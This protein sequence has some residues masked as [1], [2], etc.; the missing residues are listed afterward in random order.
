VR[1][2]KSRAALD[3]EEAVWLVA[4]ERLGAHKRLGYGSF[5][6]YVSAAVGWD[7]HSAYE[8]IRV[9]HALVTLPRVYEAL[10]EARLSW[11]AV[12]ELTR[13]ATV[14]TEKTWVDACAPLSVRDVQRLVSGRRPGDLPSTPAD[15]SARMHGLC[16]E[17]SGST[18]AL[19]KQAEDEL[20]RR[21]GTSLDH[22]AFMVALAKA[23]L[24]GE[25]ATVGAAAQVSVELCPSCRRG[26][27][28]AGGERVALRASEVERLA[29]DAR[30][31][32]AARERAVRGES[33]PSTKA[34]ADS[35]QEQVAAPSH[36]GRD[37][38]RV[39][40][41]TMKEL[42]RRAGLK[43]TTGVK[44]SVRKAVMRRHGCTCAFP[45][46]RNRVFLDLHH[47][48]PVSEGGTHDPERLLPLCEAHHQFIHDGRLVIEGTWSGGFVFLHADGTPYGTRALPDPRIAKAAE[49]AFGALTSLGFKSKEATAAVDA[50]PLAH[51][52]RDAVRRGPALGAAHVSDTRARVLRALRSGGVTCAW[53]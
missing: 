34:S 22:D 30:V 5:V 37:S 48:D 49:V 44:P 50:N 36:A 47:T 20:R 19:V 39:S 40:E 31:L 11:S 7:A 12:R 21:T 18:L 28:L 26:T 32:P 1:T 46:C 27:A 38:E 35:G 42:E 4:C 16:Y 51:R 17:V 10:A 14:E 25:S 3:A 13:V 43:V 6:E 45:G 24:T 52:A 41:A 8:R 33:P 23:F 53:N 29:C 9:A 15:D 2:G